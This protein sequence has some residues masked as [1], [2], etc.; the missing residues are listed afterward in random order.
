MIR[1]ERLEIRPLVLAD[2]EALLPYHS[3]PDVVR[4]I[5]WAVRDRVEVMAYIK[6]VSVPF[7]P[8]T[9]GS[10]L[11]LGFHRIGDGQVIGQVNAG[12]ESVADNHA[13]IGWVIN[14]EFS[15]QGYASEAVRG[16]LKYLV[17]D[18]GI[19]R[20]TA[21]I[22]QRNSDSIRLAKQLG[23][24]LEAEYVEDELFKGEWVSTSLYALLDREIR[25]SNT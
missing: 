4:Y 21:K 2:V 18:L 6:R 23:M 9:Q 3:N 13:S 1:T 8:A 20:F 11:M 10:Y 12:M 14:P 5:P 7:D 17:E 25:A 19:R 22:D 15:G 24:R 16:L